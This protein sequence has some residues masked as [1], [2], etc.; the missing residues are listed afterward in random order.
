MSKLSKQ[1]IQRIDS[2]LSFPYGCVVLRCDGDTV[3]IQVQRTKPRRYELMV[4][5]NGWFRGEYLKPDAKENR[6][7]RP[8]TVKRWKPSQRAQIIK[9][10]GKR[11]AAKVFPDLDA[12]F[13]YCM[14]SWTSS[15]SMLRHFARN[16][17]S[18]ILVSV[19]VPI[20]T[21]VDPTGTEPLNV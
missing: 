10:F 6:F 8:V 18:I 21:S 5:V 11:R 16:N 2:E 9:D 17:E 4:Y 3:T 12:T 13:T 20:D 15:G 19:G 14:S 7:Y 1:D